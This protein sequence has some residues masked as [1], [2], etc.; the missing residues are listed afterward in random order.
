MLKRTKVAAAVFLGAGI[1][2]TGAGVLAH[3]RGQPAVRLVAT[4]PEEEG[5]AHKELIRLQ[6]KLAAAVVNHDS[7]VVA[8]IISEDFVVTDSTG[9][10]WDRETYLTA[11]ASGT[12]AADSLDIDEL[13]LRVYPST[14]VVTSRNRYKSARPAMNGT[15][16]ITNTYVR[17][18]GEWRC[19]AAHEGRVFE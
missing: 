14:A 12:A 13:N 19:I 10:V 15:F 6:H 8:G 18:Q 9:H 3:G 7:G 5:D 2:A 17:L 1:L 4:R 16:R 11:I